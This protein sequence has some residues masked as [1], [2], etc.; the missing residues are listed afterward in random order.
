MDSKSYT[1]TWEPG[2]FGHFLQS[3]IIIHNYKLNIQQVESDSHLLP[4]Y[5]TKKNPINIIHPYDSKLVAKANNVIKPYFANNNLRFF[6][7]YL[8]YIKSGKSQTPIELLKLY[9]NYKDLACEKSFNI[10]MTNLFTN[11]SFFLRDIEDYLND[12]LSKN[13]VEFIE[14]KRN[15]NLIHFTNFNEKILHTSSCCKSKT[16]KDIIGCTDY[17]IGLI[18]CDYFQDD[19]VNVNKFIQNYDG[20]KILNTTDIIKHE[21]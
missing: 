1:V 8:N 12:K 19:V 5:K 11:L 4:S 9:W 6:S 13:T 17:E 21:N 10:D 7:K 20:N 18:L 3:I 16:H 15:K 14:L 2:A